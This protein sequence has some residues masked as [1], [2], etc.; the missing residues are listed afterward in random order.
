MSPI[1]GL[2]V[3]APKLSID[4]IFICINCIWIWMNRISMNINIVTEK[5]MNMKKCNKRNQL[6]V[7]TAI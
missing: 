1:N 6:H 2:E 7:K 3:V 4:K 5:K